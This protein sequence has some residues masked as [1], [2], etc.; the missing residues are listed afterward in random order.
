MDSAPSSTA[1]GPGDGS[2]LRKNHS[3]LAAFPDFKKEMDFDQESAESEY[4]Y[5]PG[6]VRK[7]Q[8]CTLHF[9]NY[10]SLYK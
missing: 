7:K 2:A 10:L 4:E 5:R 1:P 8:V 6:D 9:P 3:Q